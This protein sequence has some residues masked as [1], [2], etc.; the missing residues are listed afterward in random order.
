MWKVIRF[1]GRIVSSSLDIESLEEFVLKKMIYVFMFSLFLV[2]CSNSDVEVT[3]PASFFVGQD[4]DEVIKDAKED[5]VSKVEKNSDGSVT[6]TMSKEKHEEM[7]TEVKDSV[8]KTV[9]ELKTDGSYSSIK[10]V[11]HNDNF[12]KFTVVVDQGAYENSLEGLA[13]L[14]LAV[15]GMNY[16]FVNGTDPEKYK[17]EVELKD[18]KSGK[19]FDK[20]VYPDDMKKEE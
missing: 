7:L 12:S 13:T 5:G 8:L 15:S 19:V 18:E 14:G 4:T 1:F 10:D 3:L 11:T 2:G 6:Y 9:E 17:V 20:I 16:Q